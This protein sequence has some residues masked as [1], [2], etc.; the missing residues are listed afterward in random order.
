MGQ[1]RQ[2]AKHNLQC[3]SALQIKTPKRWEYMFRTQICIS[4]PNKPHNNF[5]SL[6]PPTFCGLFSSQPKASKAFQALCYRKKATSRDN[7]VKLLTSLRPVK[8]YFTSWL[9][10]QLSWSWFSLPF[11]T[12]SSSASVHFMLC[13]ML[14]T[15]IY[16]YAKTWT[17]ELFKHCWA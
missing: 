1:R 13:V 8:R 9:I 6:S 4:C 17:A 10:K 2:N 14:R 7:E 16:V 3:N 15:N 5:F 12:S 11:V